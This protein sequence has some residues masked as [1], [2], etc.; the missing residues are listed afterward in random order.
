MDKKKILRVLLF[1]VV[2]VFIA[3]IIAYFIYKPTSEWMA[4]YIAGCG[5]MLV[6]NLIISIIFVNKNFKDK[7]RA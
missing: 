6:L 7:D 4:F 2:F 5:G 1:I 3:T